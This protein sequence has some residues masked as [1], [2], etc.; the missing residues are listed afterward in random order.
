MGMSMAR[1]EG[2]K[3]D[4]PFSSSFFPFTFQF[5]NVIRLNIDWALHQS[6]NLNAAR[7]W[8]KH[9]TA[10][11]TRIFFPPSDILAVPNPSFCPNPDRHSMPFYPDAI[12]G[13]GLIGGS[14][15]SA[16]K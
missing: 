12:A 14:T 7:A 13:F 1:G 3:R 5:I 15:S 6:G 2:P 16:W 9:L 10:P 8:T 4:S 11:P